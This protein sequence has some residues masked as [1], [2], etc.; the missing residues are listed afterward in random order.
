MRIDKWIYGLIRELTP[1]TD[2]EVD[3]LETDARKDI[4][5][6]VIP[7]DKPFKEMTLKEK[8]AFINEHWI[9]RTILAICYLPVKKYFLEFNSVKPDLALKDDD[10]LVRLLS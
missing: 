4:G 9:F 10:E 6:I 5:Q 1:M 2:K 7:T 8:A 3:E